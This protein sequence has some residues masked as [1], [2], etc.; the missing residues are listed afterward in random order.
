M[1][2]LGFMPTV[3]ENPE[4]FVNNPENER[5]PPMARGAGLSSGRTSI[6]ELQRAQA[7]LKRH[8]I[9][10]NEVSHTLIDMCFC[11]ALLVCNR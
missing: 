2:I 6:A 3:G 4:I 11:A 8:A 7:M 5:A 10:A 1:Q 9:A